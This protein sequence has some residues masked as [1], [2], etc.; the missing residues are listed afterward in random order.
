MEDTEQIETTD[1]E[2]Q[3]EPGKPKKQTRARSAANQLQ[4]VLDAF[5][6]LLANP[7][8]KEAKR[9]DL[10][11]EKT[12]TLLQLVELQKDK[13]ES[14]IAAENATLKQDLAAANTR[15]AALETEVNA[16]KASQHPIQTVTVPASDDAEIRANLANT[17][18]LIQNAAQAIRENVEEPTR[19]K[20]AAVL[21]TRMGKGAQPLVSDIADWASIYRASQLCTEELENWITRA[22]PGARG[23]GI[24]IS[25]SV[26]AARGVP[27]PEVGSFSTRPAYADVFDQIDSGTF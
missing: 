19:L 13:K 4:E 17:R 22:A 23:S 15:V 9:A 14:E 11:I 5:D 10:L 21:C 3:N 24:H 18:D 25:K 6:E 27:I 16:L 26:L 2:Q 7:K 8:L 12:H 1:Q 20:I